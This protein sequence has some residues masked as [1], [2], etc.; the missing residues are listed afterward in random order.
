[1]AAWALLRTYL[2]GGGGVGEHETRVVLLLFWH[3]VTGLDSP[4]GQLGREQAVQ[5]VLDL[6][7]RSQVGRKHT[8]EEEHELLV[9]KVHGCGLDGHVYVHLREYPPNGLG[10]D[11]LHAC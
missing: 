6:A 8:A 11:R 5:P 10:K 9:Q 1:M 3:L 2:G 7:V 4:V